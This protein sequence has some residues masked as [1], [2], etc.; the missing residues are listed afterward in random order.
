MP[1][2]A[3]VGQSSGVGITGKLGARGLGAA[4]AGAVALGLGSPGLA[5]T[6][7]TTVT[8]V[9]LKPLSIVKIRDLD[10]G[11]IVAGTTAGTVTIDPDFNTRSR[12]GGVTLAGGSPQSAEF[13]T[14]GAPGKTLQVNRGP[15][16][17]LT[18]VG[19]GATM[20]VTDITLNGTTTKFLN[21]A[22]LFDL[23]VGGTLA[24]GANQMD[25][26]YTGTFDIIVTYY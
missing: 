26:V 10:F 21:A 1:I 7:A 17:V 5:A 19:G 23:L 22:G 25:G 6:Q 2:Y 3:R 9:A 12:T 8:V 15:L 18:R 4:C 20:N 14:Y 11:R 13:E 16:P 24:V